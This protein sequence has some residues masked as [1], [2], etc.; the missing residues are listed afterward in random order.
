MAGLPGL[1]PMPRKRALLT[2]RAVNS[3]KTVFGAKIAASVIARR[4]AFSIVAAVTA[5]MLAGTSLIS[6]ASL[7]AVTMTV[8]RTML[9]DW[10]D[11]AKDAVGARA[12]SNRTMGR[13]MPVIMHLGGAEEHLAVNSFREE[14]GSGGGILARRN[15]DGNAPAA[16]RFSRHARSASRPR[17]SRRARHR[18]G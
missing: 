10:F 3:V 8:G 9:G 12:K 7:S 16:Q 5:V 4:P 6:D 11:C 1:D 18:S 14:T 13:R 2:L 15:R 17:P